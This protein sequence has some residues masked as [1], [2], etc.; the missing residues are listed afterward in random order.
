MGFS[1][2]ADEVLEAALTVFRILDSSSKSGR[3]EFDAVASEAAARWRGSCDTEVDGRLSLESRPCID[4]SAGGIGMKS[5]LGM[6]SG[7]RSSGL[8]KTVL[9]KFGLF[10]LTSFLKW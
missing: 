10:K 5:C 2:G 4:C 7:I 1:A 9:A 8:H 6:G 3:L